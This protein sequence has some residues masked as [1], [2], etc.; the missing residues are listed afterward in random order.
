VA[1]QDAPGHGIR[2]SPGDICSY[3]FF[4]R[5][6]HR[7]A[8][9]RCPFYVPKDSTKGQLLAVRDGIGQMLEQ[10]DLTDE[11]RQALEATATPSPP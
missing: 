5:C 1:F 10:L 3:D 6:P 2:R 11:E 9:V 7:L 8:C 4:A